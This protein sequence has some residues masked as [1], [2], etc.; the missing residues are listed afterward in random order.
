M[1]EIPGYDIVV[2]RNGLDISDK[3][4]RGS[5]T[6][7]RDTLRRSWEI[8]LA[9]P[10]DLSASDTWTIKR[11]IAGYESI[12]CQGVVASGFGGQDRVRSGGRNVVRLTSSRLVWGEAS[13]AGTYELLTYCIPKTLVFVNED[14]LLSLYPQAKL[15]DGVIVYGGVGPGGLDA[16]R[17][18]HSRLP[19][20]EYESSSFECILGV[21]THH[22][23]AKHLAR[24]VGYQ[25]NT[26]TP[27]VE[28]ID[29]YTIQSG[30]TWLAAIENIFRPLWFPTIEIS[31]STIY[32]NDILS[33]S[34]EVGTVQKIVLTNEAIESASLNPSVQQN[35]ELPLD[36]L[37]VTGRRTKDTLILQSDD[38]DYT[39]LEIPEVDL[40]TN[41]TLEVSRTF[42][43]KTKFKQMGEYGGPFGL[44]NEQIEPT[45][46]KDQVHQLSF[47]VDE[48]E[49]RRNYVTVGEIIKSYGYDDV[50]VARKEVEYKYGKGLVPV[51]TIEKDYV[52]TNLPGTDI[53]SLHLISTKTTVQRHC[54]K[55]LNLTL[56]EEIFEGLVLYET[57][58]VDG[59]EYKVDPMV[60]AD[61]LRCDTTR[62][63]IETDPD[64][65][66]AVLEMT[67]SEK[68]TSI[69]R[70]HDEILIKHES[71]HDR[72][73][74]HTRTSSQIL[75]NPVRDRKKLKADH[76]F[77]KEYF[78]GSG[79][80][81][82][83]YG[84]C[85]H[86]PKTIHHDDIATEALADK[87]AARA[88]AR[89]NVESN[90]EW[91]VR[92]PFPL[93]VE[94]VASIVTLPSFE[95][96]VNGQLVTVPGGDFILM[97]ARESFR[98]YGTNNIINLS[99]ETALTVRAKY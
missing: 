98:Y 76:I 45:G 6:L 52:Y 59:T 86:P 55:A 40:S 93:P 11:R 99:V 94:S 9:E 83:G 87:V 53:K 85:F 30:T 4:V 73:T 75:N 26:N 48:S 68:T 60:L 70:T 80:L 42:S 81:I 13:N 54:R 21:Q 46:I 16:S 29:T 47:H 58:E 69:F 19:G 74:D 8:E 62:G 3:V 37:I 91:T 49:G 79:K 25:L 28:I 38:P 1:S 88:F 10:M 84:P 39:P 14:W 44:P 12:W 31:G 65:K 50:E 66:Q 33:N 7:Q 23:I 35:R 89:K 63:I 36:H 56:T 95:A 32:V 2:L 15:V 24:L 27:N 34:S 77:R 5:S 20:T 71:I 97:K 57:A 90:S 17:I 61:L 96:T 43:D 82:G 72:L 41:L 18:Y 78:S 64:T 22:A 51:R 92:I 67:L